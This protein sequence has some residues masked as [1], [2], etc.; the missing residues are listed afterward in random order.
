MKF[1]DHSIPPLTRIDSPEGRVYQT[2]TGNVY[3]SVTS[4]VGYLSQ[5]HIQEWKNK[6]GEAVA[7]EISKRATARGSLIHEN[8]E[9]FLRGDP[10][11]FGMFDS[12]SKKMWEN[13]L[14][15]LRRIEEV[16][17]METQM[18]SD[19]LEVAGTVDLIAKI[20]GKLCI[21][22]WKTSSRYK[23]ADDI[24]DYFM[25]TAAY[26]FM[27]YERTGLIINDLYIAMTTEEFGLLEFKVKS[28]EWL[29]KFVDLRQQ[30]KLKFGK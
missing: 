20:D 29:P 2:I 3:P 30:Y 28:K 4:V 21:L 1:V 15:I 9:R 7:K 19:K 6:V 16:H 25:Q 13:F 23:T 27:F 8:C 11:S 5:E 24:E 17:A 26:S 10:L 12:D 14:P 22:D 18:W